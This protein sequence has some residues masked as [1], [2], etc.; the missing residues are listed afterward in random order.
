MAHCLL[1]LFL[2]DVAFCLLGVFLNV[3]LMNSLDLQSTGLVDGITHTY[4]PVLETRMEDM[5]VMKDTWM[6][7]QFPAEKLKLPLPIQEPLHQGV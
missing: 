7:R 2:K 4:F 6:Q 3:L 5:T 1:G